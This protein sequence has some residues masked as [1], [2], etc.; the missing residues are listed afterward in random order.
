MISATHLARSIVRQLLEL[1]VSDF[2]LSPGS[3]NAP[4]SI[5]LYEANEA[6][7]ADLHVRIDERGA[8]FFALGISKAS[9]NFVA[10]ICTSG[11]AAAN[12]YPAALEAYHSGSK[13]IVITA[14][15]PARLRRTGANQTTEQRQMFPLLNSHD[16]SE[17]VDLSHLLGE[18]PIH[19]NVQF[20][21]PLL[22]DDKSDWLAGLKR[23]SKE[24]KKTVSDGLLIS[25]NGVVVVGHDR[26]GFTASELSD[27][28]KSTQWP[29]VVEDPLSFPDA[30][31]HATIFLGD[32]KVRDFLHAQTVIVVGRT[33]LSRSINAFI[34]S[35]EKLIVIDPRLASVDTERSGDLLF[36]ELPK[37]TLSGPISAT[38]PAKW[39]MTSALTAE[40]FDL[41]RVWTEQSAVNSI[42]SHLPDDAALFIGSSRPIRDVEAFARPRSGIDVYANRGLAGID[43]NISTALGIA[44]RYERAYAIVGDLTFLHDVSALVNT[45]KVNLT[46]FVIDNNGGGIFSTLPQSGVNG[47]ETIFG[48]P[49]N[50]DLPRIARG[51]GIPTD[52]VK[53]LSDIEM[54]I[55]H[56]SKGLEIVIVEVPDRDSNAA[57]VRQMFQSASNAVR[58]GN[59]LD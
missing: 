41:T 1:G 5:A 39:R 33:T 36:T 2:V 26:G 43:G 25:G 9:N 6:G 11:T 55:A 23:Q 15:R 8:G 17:I 24:E 10:V 56:Q 42:V 13:L 27:F 54:I 45:A 37:V 14:D 21:E 49:H 38:W 19:L 58:I 7:L 48:T 40:S 30:I 32:E 12:Y 59:N 53:S 51:F 52:Q 34:Q 35:A 4:L 3:R 50:Q 29:L 44:T 28:A 18:G 31:A 57:G 22:S 47:F 46:I 16:I 20:D